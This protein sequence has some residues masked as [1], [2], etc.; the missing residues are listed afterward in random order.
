M[1]YDEYDN[2]AMVMMT[3]SGVAWEHVAFKDVAVKVRRR[4]SYAILLPFN[5]FCGV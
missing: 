1:A 5:I 4:Y 3:H 2:A